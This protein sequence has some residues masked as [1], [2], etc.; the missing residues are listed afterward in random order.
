[1]LMEW[2]GITRGADIFVKHGRFNV[3][4]LY[5]DVLGLKQAHEGWTGACGVTDIVLLPEELQAYA[6]F[7]ELA[8]PLPSPATAMVDPA[9]GS[10]LSRVVQL[11]RGNTGV[12][13]AELRTQTE[14][15]VP[16]H[17]RRRRVWVG[18]Q[19]KLGLDRR[20]CGDGN[21][22]SGRSD[23]RGTHGTLM[24]ACGRM[25]DGCRAASNS[26]FVMCVDLRVRCDL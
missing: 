18:S 26:A 3:P 19:G 14:L 7:P 25:G 12:R 23:R 11:L 17:R 21:C 10:S 4:K 2:Y 15:A 13:R 9:A 22:D 8:A 1:M 5:D 16:R 6:F 20:V 24:G